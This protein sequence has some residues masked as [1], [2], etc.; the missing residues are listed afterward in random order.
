MGRLA[1]RRVRFAE[2]E[3]DSVLDGKAG[4]TDGAAPVA[5][6]ADLESAVSFPDSVGAEVRERPRCVERRCRVAPRSGCRL[7]ISC[8][9]SAHRRAHVEPR[10]RRTPSSVARTVGSRA[11]IQVQTGDPLRSTWWRFN[12][13]FLSH[14]ALPSWALQGASASPDEVTT[15]D[16]V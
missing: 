9:V 7:T 12:F 2:A 15:N 16:D 8:G 4:R 14:H 1:G 5:I 6:R 13:S 10:R 11:A 3:A